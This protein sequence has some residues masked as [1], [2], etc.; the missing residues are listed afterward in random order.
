LST[1]TLHNSAYAYTLRNPGI[2]IPNADCRAPAHVAFAYP[3]VAPPIAHDRLN[4]KQIQIDT[5][6]PEDVADTVLFLASDES[7][8][9]TAH[10]LA[11]D[12]GITEF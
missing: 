10:E 11:P 8:Y 7:R 4:I 3:D 12:A 2:R 1:R 9:I 6:Q 5:T